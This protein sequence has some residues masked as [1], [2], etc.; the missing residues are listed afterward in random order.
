M[1]VLTERKKQT[2]RIIFTNRQDLYENPRPTPN[3]GTK[4]P[5]VV[6]ILTKAGEFL[7]QN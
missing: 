7:S 5:K 4:R 1:A 3:F 6:A 2:C